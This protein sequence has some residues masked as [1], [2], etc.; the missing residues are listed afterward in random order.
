MNVVYPEVLCSLSLAVKEEH[1]V[2]GIQDGPTSAVRGVHSSGVLPRRHSPLGSVRAL[3]VGESER[4]AQDE[5]A[6]APRRQVLGQEV[7]KRGRVDEDV[8][9]RLEQV[10][11]A[12][13]VVCGPLESHDV[14]IC[15]VA[16]RVYEATLH[17]VAVSV[18]LLLQGDLKGGRVHGAE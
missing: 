6:R 5:S 8:V 7:Q 17:E 10:T 18:V 3:D 1:D 14:F 9:V 4:L 12:R 11:G 2:G 13:A 15:H 16:I